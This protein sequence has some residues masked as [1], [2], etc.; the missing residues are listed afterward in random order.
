MRSKKIICMLC[1]LVSVQVRGFSV[2]T[3]GAAIE[4]FKALFMR[5]QEERKVEQ[6]V[7]IG[8]LA[9]QGQ[10]HDEADLVK[11]IY[12]I[13]QDDSI[14]GVILKIDSGGG[15]CGAAS[16]LYQ[17]IKVLT[18]KKPVVVVIG[19]L[20]CSGAYIVAL[21]ADCII[22]PNMAEIGSIGVIQIIAKK[23][24]KK[25]R[26]SDGISGE[27]IFEI[28][29]SSPN[30]A[31]FNELGPELSS[32]QRERE[33]AQAQHFYKLFCELVVA[34]RNLDQA[35]HLKWGD[36]QIFSGKQA[37]ALGLIDKVGSYS[38]ATREILNLVKERRGIE[39]KPNI[40]EI[41]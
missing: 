4:K 30:K 18:E 6:A 36:A 9:L 34:E 19:N 14:H 12:K 41:V 35:D 22:A 23:K 37:L 29:S 21:G 28:V 27:I 5:Q 11:K 20:C 8:F 33:Q 40:I 24:V 1:M 10:I 3:V 7:N 17:E 16:L 39:G 15:S 25:F 31:I 26:D 32:E 13:E 38:D 2:P